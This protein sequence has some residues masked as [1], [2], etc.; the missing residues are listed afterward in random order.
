M[1][2]LA[3]A[4]AVV[5]HGNIYTLDDAHP[6]ARALVIDNGRI[7]Y[8]GDEASALAFAGKGARSIDAGAGLVLP[9]F[10][11]SHTHPMTSG[12]TLLR[13]RLQGLTTEE[14]VSA[15]V[16]SC[17][18]QGKGTWLLG[19]GWSPGSFAA[20]R[21]KLDAL[22]PDRPALFTTEDGF[23][24]WANSKALEAANVR[25]ATVEGVERDSRTHEPTG[26][27]RDEAVGFVKRRAPRPSEAE[28]REALRRATAMANRFGITS[29]VEAAVD[30][31]VVEA[32]RA[33][34]LAGELTVRAVLAQRVDA[35]RGPEQIVAMR[36]LRD[37]AKGR[38]LRADAAKFFLDGEIDRHTAAMLAPYA[39]SADRGQLM[40][41]EAKLD[42]LVRAL[43][44]EDFLIHMHVMGDRAMRAGLDAL[45]R[46]ARFN[47]ARDRRHQLAHIGVLDPADLPRFA[48]MSVTAD[49][50]PLF[51]SPGDPAL[52]PAAA[53]LGP[54]RARWLYPLASIRK[55]GGRVVASSDW[56]S[57]SMNP[58]E[59][60][61][62][63]VLRAPPE[64]STLREMLAA[65]TRDAAW[66]AREDALDGV[67]AVGRAA[68]LVVLDRN[69][70]EVPA[71][72]I[73]ETRVLITL[74]DG[75]PVYRDPGFDWGD[76]KRQ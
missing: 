30:A 27:L 44:A 52:E 60:I 8:V 2:L 65:Y 76:Q 24:A 66:A 68:D 26:I 4:A 32:Y 23:A 53:A 45:E 51:A 54:T 13:C 39:G 42:A 49:L 56:P 33:A 10:H 6:W 14:Q 22:V 74:L 70:F 46:A 59:A 21:R 20:D 50:Q 73:H 48:R 63:A 55:A 7:A 64:T 47:G 35:E 5:L 41:P 29:L 62:A 3:L 11:D 34:D 40:V 71:K 38:R 36:A 17:A 43:D 16:R 72:A 57:T 75:E 61:E 19:S 12:M 18:A 58:F 69:L 1:T 31:P 37:R 15:A 67:I 25:G 9:G 28:Y